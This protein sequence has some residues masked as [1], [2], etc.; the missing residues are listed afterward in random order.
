VTRHLGDTVFAV[1]LEARAPCGMVEADPLQRHL[2]LW[3]IERPEDR[4][5]IIAALIADADTGDVGEVVH[6]FG[7]DLRGVAVIDQEGDLTTTL[8]NGKECAYTVFDSKGT[9]MC[10]IELAHK[11]NMGNASVMAPD[12]VQRMSAGTG[13]THSEYNHAATEITHFLQIWLLPDQQ[14]IDPGYEQVQVKAQQKRGRLHLIA[15]PQ[16]GE[17]SVQIFSNA[18]LY[19]GLFDG[20]ESARLTLDPVRKA[21]VHVVGGE[22]NVNGHALCAGDALMLSEETAL[23]L[24]DGQKAEVIVFDLEA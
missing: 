16:G 19:A 3:T 12:D 8:V 11:D 14:G 24:K 22:L 13:V 4:L 7:H 23:E 10:G 17:Q 5:R 2:G 1:D 15:S 6:G 18:K 20:V 9:A 21:Y